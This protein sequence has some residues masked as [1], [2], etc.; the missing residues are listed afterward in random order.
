MYINST[1]NICVVVIFVAAITS[2]FVVTITSIFLN[3]KKDFLKKDNHKN[4]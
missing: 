2:I 1:Y 4:R 3:L